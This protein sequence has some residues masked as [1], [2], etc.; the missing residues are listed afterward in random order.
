MGTPLFQRIETGPRRAAAVKPGFDLARGGEIAQLGGTVAK[1]SGVVFDQLV[2]VQAANELAEGKG[3]VS[4]LIEEFSNYVAENPNDSFEKLEEKWKKVVGDI[5]AIPATLKTGL[6]NDTMKQW[7]A[8]RGRTI[9]LQAHGK[10]FAIKNKQNLDRFNV[11]RELNILNLDDAA[12]EVQYDDMRATGNYDNV[13][14]DDQEQLDLRVIETAQ[15]KVAVGNASQ[16]GFDA[17]LSSGDLNV[18]FAAIE[19]IEGLTGAQKQNAESELS[20]RVRLRRAENKVKA[21]QAEIESVEQ[22][23]ERLNQRNLSGIETF[24][25]S[26]PLTETQKTEQILRATNFSKAVTATKDNI[27]TS[28]ETNIEID[29]NLNQIRKGEIT[30][31]EGLAA[32]SELAKGVNAKEGEQNLDDIRT[33]AD[34]ADANI[35]PVLRRPVVVEGLASLDR[36]RAMRVRFVNADT[37]GDDKKRAILI[38]KIE[39]VSRTDRVNLDQWARDNADNPNFNKEFNNQVD[40]LSRPRIEEVTLGFFQRLLRPSE[41]T[42]AIGRGARSVL[43]LPAAGLAILGTEESALA[44]KRFGVLETKAPDLFKSLTDEEKASILDRFRRGETVQD[45]IDLAK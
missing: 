44:R 41:R 26:L 31:D 22:V 11:Q 30:Y 18:G 6:A 16:I 36:I 20:I 10:M 24:I 42:Q 3:Q 14:L 17:W 43:P 34:A 35:S 23:S 25:R 7:L 13:I 4:S 21:Q 5:K 37:A 1:F 12:L 33:A 15:S 32:Y 9:S 2:K 27:V 19:G 45:I 29:R 38:A 28:D 8:L 40:I 39:R